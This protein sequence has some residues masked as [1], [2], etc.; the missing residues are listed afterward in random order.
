MISIISIDVKLKKY[1]DKIVIK[2]FKKSIK[3]NEMIAIIGPSGCG[4]TT[5]LNILGLLDFEYDGNVIYDEVNTKN[6]KIKNRDVFIRKNIN[7]LFQNY[8]L[9]EDETVFNNLLLALEYE[10]INK[11][12][13][14]EMIIKSL[15]RVNLEGYENKPIY[16]LSGGEQQRIALAR[17]ML[18]KGDFVLADEPTGNLDDKNKEIVISILKKLKEL[19]KTIIVVTHDQ[20]LARTC[21][22]I[23]ELEKVK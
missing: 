13:K 15:K 17:I 22:C 9:I 14:K 21:D 11:Q 4:K 19:G 8:A 7:Y 3:L 16:T 20:A 23:I 6:L 10:K 12:K 2:N 5:L 1:E 18:K